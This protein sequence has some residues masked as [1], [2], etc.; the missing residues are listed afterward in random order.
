M[1]I[2]RTLKVCSMLKS[3]HSKGALTLMRPPVVKRQNTPLNGIGSVFYAG[4]AGVWKRELTS[5]LCT[6]ADETCLHQ[7]LIEVLSRLQGGD[8][9]R[10]LVALC[11]LETYWCPRTVLFK[12]GAERFPLAS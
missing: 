3:G 10:P 9:T 2:S 5:F 6:G 4:D 12:E 1:L 8:C 11:D 7:I